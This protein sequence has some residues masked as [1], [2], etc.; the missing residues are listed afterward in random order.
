MTT[1]HTGPAAVAWPG[2]FRNRAAVSAALQKA[3]EHMQAAAGQDLEAAA[4]SLA[5]A[6]ANAR[7]ALALLE[8]AHQDAQC[9]RRAQCPRKPDRSKARR[10]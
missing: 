5:G 4:L 10:K 6:I 7:M 9:A 2:I 3:G 8:V 1:A